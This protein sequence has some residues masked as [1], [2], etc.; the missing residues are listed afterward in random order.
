MSTSN[1]RQLDNEQILS[2]VTDGANAC[3]DPGKSLNLLYY[4]Q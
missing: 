3:K 1:I 2:G 4:K